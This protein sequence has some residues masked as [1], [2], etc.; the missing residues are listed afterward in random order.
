MNETNPRYGG[1]RVAAGAATGVAL[2]TVVFYLFAVLVRPLAAEFGWRREEIA[3][4][5]SLLVGVAALTAPAWGRLFDRHAPRRVAAAGL[6]LSGLGLVSLSTLGPRLDRLYI[7]FG[8]LGLIVAGTTAL[9]YARTLAGWFD[10]RRGH[11]FGLLLGGAAFGGVALPPLLQALIE[12]AGWR[13]TCVLAGTLQLAVAAPTVLGLVHERHPGRRVP[14]PR[15]GGARR[16]FACASYWLLLAMV[17]VGAA[18]SSGALVHF[19]PLLADHGVR[20]AQAALAVSALG[21]ATFVGRLATGALLDR[22][23]APRLACLLLALAA[24]GLALLASANTFATASVAALLLGFGVGG[25][26]DVA[27]YL[28]SRAFGERALST[29]YGFVWTAQGLGAA[30]GPLLLAR[31][32]DLTGRYAAALLPL[33]GANLL[34]GIAMLTFRGPS[35]P[36]G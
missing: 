26:F 16:A 1:W 18:G 13:A 22:Y 20:S 19:I 11:A 25:E 34:A 35:S 29:L 31:A 36:P 6:A 33:A 12:R 9:A 14:S 30:L 15:A 27:P 4:A 8:L 32:F 10:R 2:S 24:G 7:T 21:A 3:R 28:L 17:F 23:A 5:Y